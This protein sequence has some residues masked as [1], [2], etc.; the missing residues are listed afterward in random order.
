MAHFMYSLAS[1]MIVVFKK[2]LL[3][4]FSKAPV[5][6]TDVVATWILLY[7]LKTQN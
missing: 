3:F 2:K 4:M 7:S 6:K 1:I 5:L